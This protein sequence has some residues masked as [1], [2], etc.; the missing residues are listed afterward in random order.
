MGFRRRDIQ[1]GDAAARDGR[2]GE[3]CIEHAGRMMVGG[4]SSGARH[5]EHAIA[6]SERLTDIRAV[7]DVNGRLCERDL[8]HV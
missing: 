4:I 7:A 6:S 8:R 5:F 3:H 1:K 2:H